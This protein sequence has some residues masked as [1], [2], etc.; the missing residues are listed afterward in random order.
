M[1]DLVLGASQSWVGADA[2]GAVYVVPAA[3]Y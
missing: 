2:G 1:T 3:G